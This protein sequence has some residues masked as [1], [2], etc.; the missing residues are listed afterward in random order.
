MDGPVLPP[1]LVQLIIVQISRADKLSKAARAYHGYGLLPASAP[2][3]AAS[4]WTTI[5]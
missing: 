5:G 2:S 1:E 3:F 4:L